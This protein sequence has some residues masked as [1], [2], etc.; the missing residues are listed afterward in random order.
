MGACGCGGFSKVSV[1]KVAFDKAE[2]SFVWPS[3]DPVSSVCYRSGALKAK[4]EKFTEL[5]YDAKGVTATLPAGTWCT[6]WVKDKVKMLTP[7]TTAPTIL[8]KIL[9]SDAVKSKVDALGLTKF[10]ESFDPENDPQVADLPDGKLKDVLVQVESLLPVNEWEIVGSVSFPRGKYEKDELVLSGMEKTLNAADAKLSEP[11][12][13]IAM[14]RAKKKAAVEGLKYAISQLGIDLDALFGNVME[15]FGVDL[16]QTDLNA[17]IAD[18][19]CD[20]FEPLSDDELALL[21]TGTTEFKSTAIA[22]FCIATENTKVPVKFEWKGPLENGKVPVWRF[23]KN[24]HRVNLDKPMEVA[25]TPK[26]AKKDG[27]KAPVNHFEG[28]LKLSPGRYA[29]VWEVDGKTYF[30]QG[31]ATPEGD[32]ACYKIFEV[33]AI[34][35]KFV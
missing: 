30:E 15:L 5:K 26:A 19:E 12:T 20:V 29:Y 7:N 1:D 18:M 28:T 35:P 33:A 17:K 4:K 8:R 3:K 2:V 16:P 14:A 27:E 24:K 21:E 31:S 6:Y 13:Q 34:K 22:R 11:A 10:M 23:D 9:E 25:L 32:N